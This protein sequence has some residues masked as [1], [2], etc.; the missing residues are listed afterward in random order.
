MSPQPARKPDPKR[1]VGCVARSFRLTK[2]GEMA[3][4]GPIVYAMR[5]PLHS[6]D[7]VA[8]PMLL[9]ASEWARIHDDRKT[10]QR[11]RGPRGRGSVWNLLKTKETP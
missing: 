3:T 6:G 2:L 9:T 1:N 8:V 4:G 5:D 11:D 7:A 10:T